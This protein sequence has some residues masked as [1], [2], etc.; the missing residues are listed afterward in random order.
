MPKK[1]TKEKHKTAGATVN[2][3]EENVVDPEAEDGN[4]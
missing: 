4:A 2:A 1:G 3:N